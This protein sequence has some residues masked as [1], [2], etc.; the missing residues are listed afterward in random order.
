M[1]QT[2]R[3]L[4][5]NQVETTFILALGLAVASIPLAIGAG[6]VCAVLWGMDAAYIT[7][8]LAMA[9]A[10]SFG[11]WQIARAMLDTRGAVVRTVAALVEYQ[12]AQADKVYSE[13]DAIRAAAERATAAQIVNVNAGAGTMNVKNKPITYRVNGQ[14]VAGNQLNQTNQIDARSIHIEGADVR[15]FAEQLA[16][17]YPHSKS[18]WL[19][20]KDSDGK[21][22]PVE[23]PYSR[24]PMTYEIYAALVNALADAG[25]IV[26]R[27][28]RASGT[29][30]EKNAPQL[31]KMIEATYPGASAK[32]IT[33]ELP[34]A[35]SGN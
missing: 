31:V 30:V 19:A 6:I 15:W 2:I 34:A 23:L 4:T 18:K 25:A 11:A 35:T 12:N 29:L 14:I 21:P 8:G 27:G 10:V 26:G 32:G 28:E 16:A 20:V 22:R 3:E 5:K 9:G 7:A 1:N 13:A 17:G 24:L 33:L